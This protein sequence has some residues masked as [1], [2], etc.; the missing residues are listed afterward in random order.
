M[1]YKSK[2]I[3]YAVEVQYEMI[4]NPHPLWLRLPSTVLINMI[5]VFCLTLVCTVNVDSHD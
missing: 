2:K 5:N 1:C 3:S 4:W